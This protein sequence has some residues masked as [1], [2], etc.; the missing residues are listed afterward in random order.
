MGNNSD[1]P[2]PTT[3]DFIAEMMTDEQTGQEFS[4][5]Y[6]KAGFL[7]TAVRALF[8]ARKQA[9]LTQ[10]QVARLLNTKQASIA[11]LEADTEGSMSLRRYVEAALACGMVPL[12]ITLVPVSA[13]REYAIAHPEAPRTQEAYNEWLHTIAQAQAEVHTVQAENN[14]ASSLDTTA[15]TKQVASPVVDFDTNFL[16]QLLQPLSGNMASTVSGQSTPAQSLTTT[17]YARSKKS[18]EKVAA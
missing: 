13:L 5:E 3:A 12:D 18:I 4:R 9:G 8:Y 6:L 16:K 11:R 2:A 14:P 17:Y 15:L 10:E 1:V 7:S